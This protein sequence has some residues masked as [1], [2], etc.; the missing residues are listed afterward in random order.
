MR[1]E[2][3]RS[4]SFAMDELNLETGVFAPIYLTPEGYANLKQELDHLTIVKRV[5]I[6]DR[7]RDSKDHGE[8]SEDNH[9]L[10]EVKFEQA[11]V[12]SRIAELKGLFATAQILET[13]LIPTDSVGMGSYV[14]VKDSTGG[15]EFEV[16]MVSSYEANP[17][18]DLISNESPMGMALIDRGEGEEVVFEAPAGKLRYKI[19]KIRR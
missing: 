13:S 8:F 18:E 15:A 6:A 9:E 3:T 16:R 4:N 11:I 10:D 5:E 19:L 7:L 2:P 12:E 14:T 17:D 1:S